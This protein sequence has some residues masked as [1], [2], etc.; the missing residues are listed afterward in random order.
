L[1]TI[2]FASRY[3]RSV[4]NDGGAVRR[5]VGKAYGGRLRGRCKGGNVEP[6]EVA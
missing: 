5:D 2:P 4:E 3:Y 6:L 1:L